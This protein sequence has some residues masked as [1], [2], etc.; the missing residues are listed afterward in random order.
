MEIL[1]YPDEFLAKQVEPVD[2]ENPGF[3]PVALKEEMV[4][5]MLANKG[6]GLAANQVGLNKQVFVMGDSKENSTICINPT[7]LQYT[8]ETSYDTEGCLSFPGILVKVKRPTELLVEYY[9][10]NLERVVSKVEGYS[11]KCYLHELDHLLGI[12]I[13]DRVSQ[14]KWEAAVKKAEKR[15]KKLG[16]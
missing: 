12:T 11:A 7:V 13:K 15:R 14:H 5:A 10:E 6:I 16:H 2:I 3:D 8:K 4:D 1:L 9:D